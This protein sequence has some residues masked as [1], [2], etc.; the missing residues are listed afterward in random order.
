MLQSSNFTYDEIW[1]HGND[2][3]RKR[4]EALEWWREHGWALESI[5]TVGTNM[6]GAVYE[7]SLR[8][9][10]E[11]AELAESRLSTAMQDRIVEAIEKTEGP[12]AAGDVAEALFDLDSVVA[13]A[14]ARIAAVE[15]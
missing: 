15:A 11:A 4:A 5:N 10:P 14:A 9:V 3:A 7:C 2:A 8:R 6:D 1:T 12:K 13:T